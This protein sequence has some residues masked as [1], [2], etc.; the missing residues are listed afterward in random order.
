MMRRSASGL[1]FLQPGRHAARGEN[2]VIHVFPHLDGKLVARADGIGANAAGIQESL[3][4]A[5][6]G[7]HGSGLGDV[8]GHRHHM[9]I[10]LLLDGACKDLALGRPGSGEPAGRNGCHKCQKGHAP[11]HARIKDFHCRDSL[12]ILLTA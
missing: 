1:H 12:F 2:A 3:R 7:H 6:R 10:A 5:E 11:G 4:K 9:G 8:I